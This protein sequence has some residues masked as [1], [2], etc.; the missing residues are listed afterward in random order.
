MSNTVSYYLLTPQYRSMS[1]IYLNKR[2]L[3]NEQKHGLEEDEAQ[4]YNKLAELLA[5]IWEFITVQA[6]LQLKQQK[7]KRK[8]DKVS[9]FCSS[10]LSAYRLVKGGL[11]F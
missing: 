8:A 3:R 11:R 4:H 1:A 10:S 9:L 5:H 7:E 6:E 2:L